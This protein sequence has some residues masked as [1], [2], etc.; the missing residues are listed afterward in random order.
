MYN[1]DWRPSTAIEQIDSIPRY[2][3]AIAQNFERRSLL[4][5]AIESYERA[6]AIDTTANFN[7]QTARLYGEQGEL[8]LMFEKYLDLM[9]RNEQIIPRIQAVFSQYVTD[10]AANAGNQALRKTLLLRLRKEPRLLYNQ[11][12]SWLFVQ[13]KDFN[14]AFI[15]ERAIYNRTKENMFGLQDLAET[16]HEEQDDLAAEN[17][18]AYIIETSQVARIRYLAE[19][20]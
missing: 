1:T 9:E 2:G 18:L 6:M 7:F 13:Q 19:V 16:A 15:Q 8:N 4:K 17:I 11:I 12:L 5:E 3:Y 14:A 10:D 20:L